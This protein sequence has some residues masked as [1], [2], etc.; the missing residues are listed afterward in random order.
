MTDAA[1]PTA[2][3]AKP[4]FVSPVSVGYR[5]YAITLLFI[6][7]VFN[8]IDRQIVAILAEPIKKELGIADWQ[9]GLMTGTAF[10]L[11][12]CTLGIPIARLSERRNRPWIIGLSLAAW[13]GFTALCGFAQNFWQLVLARVGVGVGE[14]GCTPPAHSLISDYVPPNKRATALAFYSMGNPVGALIGVMAG[15][16]IADAFGWRWALLVVGLPG[17]VLAILVVLTLFEPRMKAAAAAAVAAAQPPKTSFMDVL[18]LLR[19][20]R[21]FWLL[22][23]A[24]SIVAF[25]SYGHAPFTASFFFRVHGEEIGLLGAEWGLGKIG[26]LS[27]VLGLISGASAAVGVGLGGII[28]DHYGAKDLKAYMT[29]PAIAMA[30]TLPIYVAAILMPSFLPVLPLLV[31]NGIIG[32]TWAGPSYAT[33]QSIVPPHMRATAAAIFLFIANLIGLGVGPLA[34]GIMSDVFAGPLGMG[35][36]EGVRWALIISQFFII[37]AVICFW[38]A[39]RTIQ[40]DMKS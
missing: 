3:A 29:I 12:Y 26:F 22:S 6:V 24:T 5:N 15:G 7:Y 36:G 30:V 34:V 1:A 39:R 33:V 14:A 13:S 35:E 11:F 21:T 40:G 18:R 8:F 37:P 20:N 23:I 31:L 32:G 2:P 9:I 10:A 16:L 4:A 28:A 27:I 25:V 19:G 38:L 17:I